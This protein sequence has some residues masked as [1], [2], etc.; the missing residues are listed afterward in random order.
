[1]FLVV[2]AVFGVGALFLKY[3]MEHARSFSAD[4]IGA[5]IGVDFG[6]DSLTA[7][8]VRTLR[9]SGL[10]LAVPVPGLGHAALSV[11]SLQVTLSLPDLL[12]GRAVAGQAVITG[13]RLVIEAAQ[14]A[15][16][17]TGQPRTGVVSPERFLAALPSLVVSGS[18]CVIEW[19]P[20]Q[21]GPPLVLDAI[22]FEFSNR[23]DQRETTMHLTGAATVQDTV[24]AFSVTGV[25]RLPDVLDV[26]V[27]LED[28]TAAHLR[29]VVPL[30][31]AL[32]GSVSARVRAYGMLDERVT[33]EV[34][35]TITDAT[36]PD[37]PEPFDSV[38]ATVNALLAW[39]VPAAQAQILRAEA[40]TD[41]ARADARGN[42]DMAQTPPRMD[43]TATIG[44]IAFAELLDIF[45]PAQIR[46]L[47]A[48]ELHVSPDA[49][50]RV[51]AQGATNA[52]ET[53][54]HFLAPTLSLAATPT[55]TSLPNGEVKLE[56][57]RFAWNDFSTLPTGAANLVDGA[58]HAA[59]F[60]VSA[61]NLAGLLRLDDEGLS[62]R[63]ITAT[64]AGKPWSGTVAYTLPGGEVRF[65]VNGALS[66]IEDTPLYNITNKLWLGGDIAF[67]GR[68]SYGADGRLQLNASADVTRGMVQFEWWLRKPVGVGASIHHIEVDL[69]PG[70]TLDVQGEASIE[71]TRIM[72]KLEYVHTGEKFD[73]TH[74]RVDVP[75]LEI[76][77]A[78]KC[79]QIP[80]KALG[81]ACHDAYYE[82]NQTGENPEDSIAV[83]G[84]RFDYVS[85]LP[86]GGEHP[87]ICRDTEV[88]VTLTNIEGVERSAALE[89]QAAE[90][91]VPPFGEDWLLHIGPTDPEY[92]KEFP[93]KPQPWTYKLAADH[94]SVPPWEGKNFSAEIYSNEEETGFHFFRADVG[95][96]HIE[97]THLHEKDDNVMHIEAT[98][99]SIPAMYL[100][101]HLDLP[102]ILEG[103]ITG[104]VAYMVDQ[105][106]P[107]STLQAEGQF[108]IVD[109]H[110]IPE[111]LALMFADTLG[112]SFISLHPDALRFSEVSS[113]IRIEGDQ[114]RTNDVVINSE[115]MRIT[116]NGVWVMEGDLD[117]RVDL[118]VAPDL[119]EQIPILRDNFNV[120]GFRMTQQ[121]IE[122]GFHLTGPTFEPTGQLAGLPPIGVTIVSGAAEMTGEAIRLLDTPRQMFMSIFRIGGGIFGATRTQQQQRQAE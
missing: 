45:L 27:D 64:V 60:G 85:F 102:E 39:D 11:E 24:G 51:H 82:S 92:I 31:D 73:S 16:P 76:N 5:H 88:K 98:W 94:L 55:D 18:D 56:Q 97:G 47:G 32:D 14:S 2:S 113:D 22:A 34:F 42:L 59:A 36:I 101:R 33:A 44:D 91:H 96:G 99:E 100:I 49:Q 19:R 12:F 46:Q 28:I 63:P 121:D 110:F 86:D 66:N 52:L 107:Q 9:V 15:S 103:D 57:A 75:H 29:P 37:A 72:A 74:I 122:L 111:Q 81:S 84:G 20:F 48:F 7:E 87:L 114:I 40:L 108:T 4:A 112:S 79:V 105:D 65:D 35:T 89:V 26:Q 93:S 120:Q 83:I 53:E 13:G 119:A 21:D 17:R 25:Y 61:E 117:Y 70:Q 50:I 23:P 69:K 109:G 118:A 106:D 3:R 77:S 30:P 41:V 71:D 68:G 58:V 43:I 6:I 10:R 95:N 78:G 80:Y 115:G 1:M 62:L 38:T 90:A 54:V 67:H 8:G 104:N 116:A